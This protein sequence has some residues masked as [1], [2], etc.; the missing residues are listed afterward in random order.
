MKKKQ[1][2]DEHLRF[3]IGQTE[4]YATAMATCFLSSS[5]PLSNNTAST[6]DDDPSSPITILYDNEEEEEK[7]DL[8][9]N[10]EQTIIQQSYDEIDTLSH[11]SDDDDD[12]VEFLLTGS[13]LNRV[14]DES[15]IQ[16]AEA[17]QTD[18]E[19]SDELQAL[20]DEGS[21]PIEA[22]KEYYAKLEQENDTDSNI[23]IY[24]ESEED[25]GGGDDFIPSSPGNDDEYSIALQEERD[26]ENE[27]GTE[28]MALL[29]E[30]ANLSIE[31]LKMKYMIPSS[32]SS[33]ME[34]NGSDKIS[35]STDGHQN[36][37]YL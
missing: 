11:H 29:E 4:K 16:K 18:K 13:E 23:S 27:N 8:D 17:E 3:L 37:M 33:N 6:N 36:C 24:H 26:R 34:L 21:M 2:M 35:V 5:G 25:E 22:L 7:M 31:E 12:D 30:E 14:D 10:D 1:V 20:Q 19:I 9:E 15:T 32:P 28:E